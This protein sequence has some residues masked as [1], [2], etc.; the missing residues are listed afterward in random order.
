[1]TKLTFLT[2][3][4][5]EAICGGGWPMG[6]GSTIT[7]TSWVYSSASYKNSLRQSNFA[8]NL[9]FGGGK[10]SFAGVIN[11]QSNLAFQTIAA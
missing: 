2:E 7:T 6:G 10:N 5:L 1:M 4:Q 9:V 8:T 3:P 11:E